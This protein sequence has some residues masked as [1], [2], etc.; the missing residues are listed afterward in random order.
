[1]KTNPNYTVGEHTRLYLDALN[2][3]QE[4]KNFFLYALNDMYGEEKGTQFFNA[5]REQYE[6]MENTIWNYMRVPITEEMGIESE[7]VE[8]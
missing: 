1:M 7:H 6:Q 3:F 5:H 4:F 8:I 2:V